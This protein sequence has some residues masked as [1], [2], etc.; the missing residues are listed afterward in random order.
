[1]ELASV[2]GGQCEKSP[3]RTCLHFRAHPGTTAPRYALIAFPTSSKSSVKSTRPSGWNRSRGPGWGH[4]PRAPGRRPA[5]RG[6]PPGGGRVPGR[7]AEQHAAGTAG[8]RRRHRFR[9]GIPPGEPAVGRV[10]QSREARGCLGSPRRGPL[11][12]CSTIQY[13]WPAS[14]RKSP[15]GH[16]HPR[17]GLHSSGDPGSGSRAVEQ[18]L[19]PWLAVRVRG[20]SQGNGCPCG[21]AVI[22]RSTELT[23]LSVAS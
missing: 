1:V 10:L 11:E 21:P 23:L 16:V 18:R 12:A 13:R 4:R 14:K 2:D 3:L 8:K 20:Q 7:S 19:V 6:G 9:R 22:N 17:R 5:G 15:E